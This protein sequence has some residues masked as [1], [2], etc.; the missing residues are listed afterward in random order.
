MRKLLYVP[1]IHSEADLGSLG[2]AVERRS[3]SLYGEKRWVEHK[4]T[5]ARFWESIAEYLLSLDAASLKLYQDGLAADGELGRRIVEEAAQRG[6][7]NYRIL[8]RLMNKGA[9]LRK[10]EDA[11]LLAQE[12]RLA[13]EE[14][15]VG[16]TIY[17]KEFSLRKARLTEERDKFIAS[18]IVETLEQ[19]ETGILFIGAYHNVHLYLPGDIAVEQLKEPDKVNAYFEELV[20]GRGGETFQCLASYLT[21]PVAP[22]QV[23]Y[24]QRKDY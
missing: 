24:H 10:T 9:E 4:E 1:I 23:G 8:L 22:P 16:N 20:S 5:V 12:L 2:P 13:Q 17:Q 19:G 11:S 14:A 7:M 3:A 18:A 21:S 15:V 6:S